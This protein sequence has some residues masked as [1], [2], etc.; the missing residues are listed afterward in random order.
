MRVLIGC[1]CSGVIRR[2]FRAAGFSAWSCDLRPAMD[3]SPYHMQ[4]DVLSVVD[5]GWDLAIF[6]PPCTRLSNA[7]VRWL[8][9]RD[10]WADLERAAEFFNRLKAARI[11][12][13]AVE[14][15]KPHGYAVR[16]IGRPDD[17][18]EPWQFG[19]PVKK[20][21]YF[22]L[23]GLPPLM[24]TSDLA[25]CHA[26]TFVDA[27]PATK[28]RALKRAISFPGMAAAMADQWGS[29]LRG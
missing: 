8:A 13:V 1:E 2:A 6:H 27:L 17:A 7:G 24:P 26:T 11:P 15:P 19:D 10:L 25:A 16:L 28:D 21:T 23:R 29:I 22:W 5:M 12:R 3:G 14:N 9:A 4:T 20:R 18:V